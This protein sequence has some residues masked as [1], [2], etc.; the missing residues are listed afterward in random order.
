MSLNIQHQ[1]QQPN[2]PTGAILKIIAVIAVIGAIVL[3]G[4][5]SFRTVPA[6]HVG[7][8][9]LFGKIQTEPYDEGLH[10][11]I[12][13]LYKWTIYDV[14]EK[15]HSEKAGVPSQDQLTT[16]LDVSVQYRINKAMAPQILGDTGNVDQMIQVH[17]V[18]KVRSLL[19]E[20]GKSIKR[21]EDFFLEETQ[22]SLQD[23]LYTGLSEY[24]T[25]KGIEVKAVL[26]RDI[27]LPRFI[28]Q[29]IEKKKERE[30]AV[31][32][33][34]AELER[35]RMEQQEKVALAEAEKAAAN[36]EAEKLKVLADAKAY[37][38]ERINS[39]I[40][41]NPAYI[42]LEAL[43]ALES[44]SKDP[45]AKLYFMSGD[46]P[47]PLPLMHMGDTTAKNK[48]VPRTVSDPQR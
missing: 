45:A 6:G 12:N 20:Q 31:E 16:D 23:S 33:Q 46:S 10:S 7:V 32:Q 27:R 19:R 25:P 13:P 41:N 26:L 36:S 4:S 3:V 5:W 38:I 24:L 47:M 43:K 1:N 9:T 42:Q 29:A 37:E 8:A 2:L 17:L 44:I 18:P 40:A 21:A 11:F 30:Q 48:L 28:T 34:K 14:R 22:Q 15:T 35:F 39:A